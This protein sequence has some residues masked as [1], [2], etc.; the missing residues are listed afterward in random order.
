MGTCS[1][2]LTLQRR[3]VE[4]QM[5]AQFMCRPIIRMARMVLLRSQQSWR[6][7]SWR[8]THQT[9]SYGRGSVPEDLEDG[10][11]DHPLLALELRCAQ[12]SRGLFF[13]RSA[14]ITALNRLPRD[15]VLK[16]IHVV[17]TSARWST[18]GS[19]AS[20]G[21]AT[22]EPEQHTAHKQVTQSHSSCTCTCAADVRL[23]VRPGV[24]AVCACWAI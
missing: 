24:S 8:Y 10:A 20:P 2:S 17:R 5:S 7:M 19:A 18:F 13:R 9:G 23:A 16:R 11:S 14:L 6:L 21:P 1:V 12:R 22:A 4:P 15:W 3:G